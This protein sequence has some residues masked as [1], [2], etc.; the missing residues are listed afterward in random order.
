[1]QEMIVRLSEMGV[2]VQ[3]D[4]VLGRLTSKSLEVAEKQRFIDLLKEE[5]QG[6]RDNLI[7][8]NTLLK[9]ELEIVQNECVEQNS[10]IESC[11]KNRMDYSNVK[12]QVELIK[13]I[14]RDVKK[15]GINEEAHMAYE[16]VVELKDENWRKR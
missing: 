1:M 11:N 13:E 7:E 4:N 10:I 15:H 12:E 14:N 3:N 8:K 9:K 16:Y 2:T 6:C 5:I